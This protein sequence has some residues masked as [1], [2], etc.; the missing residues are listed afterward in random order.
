[1]DPVDE[2]Y[3]EYNGNPNDSVDPADID[4]VGSADA[5]GGGTSGG[6][7][8]VEI[9]SKTKSS[10][11]QVPQLMLAPGPTCL[12]NIDCRLFED[13]SQVL[14]AAYLLQFQLIQIPLKPD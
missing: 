6:S 11:S 2:D 5:G 4:Y 7:K 9:W 12:N 3:Y 14:S 13:C 10:N 1:M 8:K